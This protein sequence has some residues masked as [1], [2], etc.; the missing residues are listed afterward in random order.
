M[1]G[2]PGVVLCIQILQVQDLILLRCIVGV[3]GLE[4][5]YQ[6]V[7]EGAPYMVPHIG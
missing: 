2:E 1:S 5:L 3:K 4:Q 7:E 6:D